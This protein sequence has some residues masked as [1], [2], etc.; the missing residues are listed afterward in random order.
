[1]PRLGLRLAL[2]A[3]LAHVT[4]FGGG[5]GE[6]Y[7]DSR[8]AARIDRF[9]ATVDELQTP[10]VFPQENGNRTA[11]RWATLLDE[12]GHGL[13]VEGAPT[14]ELTARR[15]TSEQLA[16]ARHTVD[17][18]AGDAIHLNLDHAQHGLGSGSCGPAVLPRYELRAEPVTFEVRLRA[19]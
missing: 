10:Y 17:L 16:A 1:L 4:W 14:V 11:V 7:A 9:A 18:V 12:T 13:R 8:Q 6:A 2:P 3:A 15:W 5:P 19:I